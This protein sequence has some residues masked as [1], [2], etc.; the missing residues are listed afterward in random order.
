MTI[1]ELIAILQQFPADEEVF[2]YLEVE[3]GSRPGYIFS[4]YRDN[5]E[6]KIRIDVCDEDVWNLA[7]S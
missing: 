2:A 7:D 4:V 3:E 5:W 6:G 1:K